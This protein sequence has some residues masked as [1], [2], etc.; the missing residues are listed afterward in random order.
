VWYHAEGEEPSWHVTSIPQI[1]NGQWWY[2]GRNE[3]I[4]NSHIQVR[5]AEELSGD[6]IHIKPIHP[7][8]GWLE[9][10][11]TKQHWNTFLQE[12]FGFPLQLT[13]VV[14]FV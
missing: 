11:W 3:F 12:Y 5:E 6:V 2:R 9:F 10:W 1:R 14:K 8:Y 13:F 4:V 7:T